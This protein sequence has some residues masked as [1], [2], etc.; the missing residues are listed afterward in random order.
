MK[1]LAKVVTFILASIVYFIYSL[2]LF[3]FPLISADFL[4]PIDDAHLPSY[5]S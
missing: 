5:P 3:L 4:V 2:F 1:I